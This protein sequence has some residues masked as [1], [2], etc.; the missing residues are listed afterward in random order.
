MSG[1]P[2]VLT[3]N[4]R[5]EEVAVFANLP[6]LVSD[7]W[8]HPSG[9]NLLNNTAPITHYKLGQG[10]RLEAVYARIYHHNILSPDFAEWNRIAGINQ[11]FFPDLGMIP[12]TH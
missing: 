2:P 10:G 1:N 11:S 9:N 5:A 8:A 7:Y 3:F 4:K 12:W 6:D